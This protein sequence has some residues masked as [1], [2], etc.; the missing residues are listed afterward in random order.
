MELILERTYVSRLPTNGNL[1]Y[2]GKLICHTLE[3]PWNNNEH[4]ISCIEEGTYEI[5]RCF[6]TKFDW[7]F[8]LRNVTNR[9]FILIHPA[10]DAIKELKGCIAPVEELLRLG[11]GNNSKHAMQ[12]LCLL[13]NPPLK[14]GEKVYLNISSTKSN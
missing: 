3:L 2:Q 14:R 6:S 5:N 7:H 13:L 8:I 10:N 11:I 4:N 1:L 12:K 9:K